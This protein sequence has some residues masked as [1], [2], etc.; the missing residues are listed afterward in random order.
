MRSVLKL[1][2][3]R[4]KKLKRT[5]RTPKTNKRCLKS[6]RGVKQVI[7]PRILMKHWRVMKWQCQKSQSKRNSLDSR[8]PTYFHSKVTAGGEIHTATFYKYYWRWYMKLS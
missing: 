4:R 2:V 6:L 5:R 8:V 3:A 1:G 7:V